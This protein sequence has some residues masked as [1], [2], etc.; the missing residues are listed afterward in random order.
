MRNLQA[1][2]R[3]EAPDATYA[4]ER[5][6]ELQRAVESVI[7]G[8]PEVVRL[9]VVTLLAGGRLLVEDVPGGVLARW[10]A[11]SPESGRTA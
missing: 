10:R 9:A 8:K 2:D 6:A 3:Q 4:A 5:V 7:K 11:N 1:A